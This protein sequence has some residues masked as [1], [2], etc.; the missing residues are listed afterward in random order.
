M[1]ALSTALNSIS[2]MNIGENMN[3]E[4]CWSHDIEELIT[5]FHFQLTRGGEDK[6]KNK[7]KTLLKKIFGKEYVNKE[8]ANMIYRMIGYTRDIIN[9]K[10]EYTLSYMLVSELYK[11]SESEDCPANNKYKIRAMSISVLES[12]VRINSQEHPYGSWKDLKYFCNYH[13]NEK[14]RDEESLKKINDPLFTTIIN[15]MCGQLQ[16]DENSPV[17]TL[18]A[19]WIPREKSSKFGWIARYLALQYYGKW[20][21]PQL[22]PTQYKI[23][24]RKCLTHFRQ[25]VSKINKDINTPQINQCNGTWS[26]INFDKN[27]SSITLRKQGKAFQGINKSTIPD[28]EDRVKCSN[29]YVNYVERCK[30]GTS[31]AKGKR[32]SIID[33]VR[34]ALSTKDDVEKT[35]IN[36]QWRDNAKQNKSLENCIAM[37]DISSSMETDKCIPLYSAIGLGLRIAEKSK[38]G[39]RVLTFNSSPSWIDLSETD[40]FTSMV[41]KVKENTSW[42]MNTNFRAALDIILECAITNN[43]SPKDM[44]NMTLVI[45]SDMQIDDSD[46]SQDKT[47]M[48]EMMKTKYKEAGLKSVFCEGYNLPHIVFWNLRTTSGFPSLTTTSNTSMMSGN[49][50]VMLNNFCEKGVTSLKDITPWSYLQQELS[51]PRYNHLGNIVNNIWT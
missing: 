22:S 10:G 47:V 32:V 40:D 9:G 43:I 51:N 27:V 41:E 31:V 49:N 17:K 37:I 8:Y 16:C 44:K 50:P 3:K 19:K 6:L 1:S 36:S 28:K 33:F 13:I 18:V 24:K 20:I 2:S 25:L 35:I 7:Y 30:E 21:T 14:D 23:A 34:D 39:R 42:G 5:Q 38:L 4:Y 26:E 12:F 45:L 11:F 46:I 15:L 29:N 48:F